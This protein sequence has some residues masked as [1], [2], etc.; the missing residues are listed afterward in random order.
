M[1]FIDG[2]KQKFLDVKA[3]HQI[4]FES[5]KL[6]QQIDK[7]SRVNK[8]FDP[9]EMDDDR[10]SDEGAKKPARRANQQKFKE[11][12]RNPQE[13][14]PTLEDGNT[15]AF[16]DDGSMDAPIGEINDDQ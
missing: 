5:L 16:E 11:I 10:D 6:A 14:F 7:E 2:E 12:M 3:D 1:K 4:N 15:E 8:I 9:N 13:A